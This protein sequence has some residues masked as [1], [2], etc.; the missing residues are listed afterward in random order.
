MV[1][2]SFWLFSVLTMM[3]VS[4]NDKTL[5]GRVGQPIDDISLPVLDFGYCCEVT[6]HK[7]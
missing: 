2:T 7:C 6:W 1:S 5:W 4:A 3:S